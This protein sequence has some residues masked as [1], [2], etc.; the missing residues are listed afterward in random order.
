M[1][2]QEQWLTL[3]PQVLQPIRRWW[4]EAAV[5]AGVPVGAV[6]KDRM[7]MPRKAQVD[8]L[9]DTLTYKEAIRGGG[10]TLS[11]VLRE[12][13]TTLDAFIEERTYELARLKAANIV[14]DTDAAVSELGLS[15]AEV[16]KQ[17]SET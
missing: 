12:D 4:Q 2:E 17:P 14:T 13:G 6:V 8:P 9:K 10:R 3:V 16:L 7:S 5:L 1:I 11:D 15:A